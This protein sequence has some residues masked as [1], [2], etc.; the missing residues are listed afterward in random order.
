MNHPVFDVQIG[1]ELVA[2]AAAA[3]DQSSLPVP[4]SDRKAWLNVAAKM[5]FQSPDGVAIAARYRPSGIK[6]F[7]MT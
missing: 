5:F 4:V 7:G 1:H 6:L 3:A 2:A